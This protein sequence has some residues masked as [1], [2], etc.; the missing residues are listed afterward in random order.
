MLPFTLDPST[1]LFT[2]A[3]L[4]VL[5]AGMTRGLTSVT[6]AAQR[7]VISWTRGML[8]MGLACLL[9]LLRGHAS[10]YASFVA[11]NALMLAA[12]LLMLHA[13][14]RLFDVR[15]SPRRLTLVYVAQLATV[16]AF[17]LLGTSRNIAIVTLSSFASAEF[18]IASALLL[19]SKQRMRLAARWLGGAALGVLAVLSAMRVLVAWTG[20]I[21]SIDP[22]ATSDLQVVTLLAASTLFVVATVTFVLMVNDRHHREA[23]EH[24]RRDAL[25][26]VLTRRAFF[27]EL[28]ALE[29]QPGQSFALVMVDIDHFK[30][31]NDRHGHLGGD[32]VLA[33]VGELLRR[34]IRS[35]D[36]AG[37]YGG[38]EFCVLLRQCGEEQAKRFAAR[39]V[40]AI[41]TATIQM[42][43][44]YAATF[45]VSAGYAVGR[46][47]DAGGTDASLV[48][49][50]LARA[51]SALYEAKRTGRNRAVGAL[52]DTL[53]ASS[54]VPTLSRDVI[55]V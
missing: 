48:G 17:H 53:C 39:L 54:S 45:T 28:A 50:V 12:P 7:A 55:A 16:V 23:L 44:G 22:A 40:E 20:D 11:A 9:Y 33:H 3:L 46:L 24:A 42:P 49:Q 15:F 43:D 29:Q 10:S 35:V 6:G 8:C 1:L 4:G 47:I 27:D 18:A 52:K 13:Y 2:A 38:E 51:D 41:G 31:I 36:V 5:A 19:L 21:T 26:G 30:S 14:L 25:T 34:T 37:R 32:A